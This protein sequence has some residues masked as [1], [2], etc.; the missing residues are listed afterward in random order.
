MKTWE[1]DLLRTVK[2]SPNS[3]GHDG[4]GS[5]IPPLEL[6][7]SFTYSHKNPIVEVMIHE[8]NC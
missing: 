7:H 1:R 6:F 3:F 4:N 8:F 2:N 5:P